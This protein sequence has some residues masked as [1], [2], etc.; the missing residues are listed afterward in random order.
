MGSNGATVKRSKGV[1]EFQRA[2][3]EGDHEIAADTARRIRNREATGGLAKK[4]GGV[5]Q[6]AGLPHETAA[7][8]MERLNPTMRFNNES[9]T[10][11]A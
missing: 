4:P 2:V 5:V 7:Q 10:L 8:N 11:Y 9:Q 6:A 3:K 1:E